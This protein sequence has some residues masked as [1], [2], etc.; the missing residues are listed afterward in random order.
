MTHKGIVTLNERIIATDVLIQIVRDADGVGWSGT[1]HIS[2][3][4][5]SDGE[6]GWTH[7]HYAV[8]LDGGLAGRFVVLSH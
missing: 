8:Q 6:P 3:D 2:T 1:L 4:K 7:D 5:L